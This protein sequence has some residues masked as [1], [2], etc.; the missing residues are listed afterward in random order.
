LLDI[1]SGE[2]FWDPLCNG[3]VGAIVE[4]CNGQDD[5][6]NG[7]ADEGCQCAP[8]NTRVCGNS[9]GQCSF[10]TQ[11]CA[12]N[13]TWG[14]VCVGAVLP[15]PELC[16]G[17]DNDCNGTIDEGCSCLNGSSRPCGSGVGV[18][19]QGTQTCANGLWGVCAGSVGPVYDGPPNRCDALDNDC[20]GII[21]DACGCVSG[22]TQ[23]CGTDEGRCEPGI[24]TCV[25]GFW[26]ACVGFIGPVAE[27]CG[28]GIDENCNGVA[29]EAPC[30]F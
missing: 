27:I 1:V 20:N 19:S 24:T 29:D 15:T 4:T 18:C 7:V 30:P 11:T 3:S 10:G 8:G 13:G 14:G 28:N 25:N 2:T 26:G 22:Q 9:V 5:D 6:C 16:D 21:D 17:V 12:A 23:V